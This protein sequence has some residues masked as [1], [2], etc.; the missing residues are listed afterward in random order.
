MIK[1][2]YRDH[3]RRIVVNNN[4]GASLSGGAPL[5]ITIDAELQLNSD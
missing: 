5:I 2:G 3:F 4:G 1:S